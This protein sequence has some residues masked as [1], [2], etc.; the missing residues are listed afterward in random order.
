MT[1]SHSYACVLCIA[2]FLPVT[3]SVYM[4]L[5]QHNTHSCYSG[6]TGTNCDQCI[7]HNE[8]CI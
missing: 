4:Y 8:C 2:Y 3:F 1:D 7:P 5:P 6:W